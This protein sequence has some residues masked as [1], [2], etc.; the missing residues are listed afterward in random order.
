MH[1]KLESLLH[2]YSQ[3]SLIG[4]LEKVGEGL[5]ISKQVMEP[6]SNLRK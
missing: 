4:I 2:I 5:R 3:T 1:S 6:S